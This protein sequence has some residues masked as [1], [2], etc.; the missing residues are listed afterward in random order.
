MLLILLALLTIVSHLVIITK[1]ITMVIVV[2][3]IIILK[4]RLSMVLFERAESVV[5]ILHLLIIHH[6]QHVFVWLLFSSPMVAKT[7]YYR[8]FPV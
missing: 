4:E 7:V 1:I 2:A 5:F 6:L 3:M 8:L